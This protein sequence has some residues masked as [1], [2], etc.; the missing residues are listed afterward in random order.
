GLILG[1]AGDGVHLHEIREDGGVTINNG[2]QNGS[3]GGVILGGIDGIDIDDVWRGDIL[4]DNSGDGTLA[5]GLIVGFDEDGIE[6]DHADGVVEIR[7]MNT[8]LGTPYEITAL[9][10]AAAP[11]FGGDTTVFGSGYMSGIFG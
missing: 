10:P 3:Q 1:V 7:N 2:A 9:D 8:R 11:L 6:I 5:G 4:I